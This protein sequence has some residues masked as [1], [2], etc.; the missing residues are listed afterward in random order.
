MPSIELEATDGE[1]VRLDDPA[2][3]V[4]YVY[5]RSGQPGVEMPASDWDQI[6]GARGCTTQACDMRDHHAELRR[7]GAHRVFGLSTQDSAYQVRAEELV[8]CACG[9]HPPVTGRL[10]LDRRTS[11]RRAAR[12]RRP[13]SPTVQHP[14]G[15][16]PSTR[17]G[18]TP[19]NIPGGG[20]DTLQA[21]DDGHSRRPNR[22]RLLSSLSAKQGRRGGRRV[23]GG[24]SGLARP[25][26][27]R[28]Q[29]DRIQ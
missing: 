8:R 19:S 3:T 9:L 2:R 5:P 10:A 28:V 15:S 26:H 21:A 20:R 13:P 7:A 16:R 6:P 23:A 27:R 11:S 1:R 18:A 29:A 25:A 17:R 12:A 4:I 24:A 22:A 14:R